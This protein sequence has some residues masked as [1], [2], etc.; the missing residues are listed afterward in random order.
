M[1]RR[2]WTVNEESAIEL[3]DDYVVVDGQWQFAIS[4][5]DDVIQ[6]LREIQRTAQIQE[7]E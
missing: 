4:E 7:T 1:I 3:V 6:V 2:T 5:I